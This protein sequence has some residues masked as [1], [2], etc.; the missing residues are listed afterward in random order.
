MK[1]KE[2]SKTKKD[3]PSAGNCGICHLAVR[4]VD[5]YVKIE[6]Y[7]KGKKHSEGV[8]HRQCFRERISG[9]P[10]IKNLQSMARSL[11]E[12]TGKAMSNMGI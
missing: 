4:Y 8:Y 9:T 6:D 7:I 1:A 11:M 3:K 5:D 2:E 10:E 12:R